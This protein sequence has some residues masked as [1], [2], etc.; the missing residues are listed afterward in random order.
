M[1]QFE[2]KFSEVSWLTESWFLSAVCLDCGLNETF[3][4]QTQFSGT[5]ENKQ[6]I[7]KSQKII[8]RCVKIIVGY[9]ECLN[10]WIYFLSDMKMSRCFMS[11]SVR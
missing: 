11:A 4:I 8:D 7:N 9:R 1:N 3:W 5:S 2:S 10:M 6:L